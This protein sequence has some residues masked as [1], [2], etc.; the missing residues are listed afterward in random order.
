MHEGDRIQVRELRLLERARDSTGDVALLV[1]RER[2]SL[3]KR[4]W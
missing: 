3:G 1:G 4:P 2:Q